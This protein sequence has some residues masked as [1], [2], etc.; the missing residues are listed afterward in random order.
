MYFL[1]YQCVLD[2]P[3]VSSSYLNPLTTDFC[4]LFNYPA[5]FL[6]LLLKTPFFGQKHAVLIYLLFPVGPL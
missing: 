6:Q 5:K 1:F 3:A 2:G 4:I